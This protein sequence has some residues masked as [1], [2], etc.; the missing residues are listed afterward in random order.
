MKRRL[1]AL[2]GGV[3]LVLAVALPSSAGA[4]VNWLCDVPGEGTVVFVSA[5][6]A[7]RHGLVTAN[8]HAGQTF[9]RNFGKSFCVVKARLT[10][11]SRGTS[12]CAPMTALLALPRNARKRSYARLSQAR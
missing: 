4:N 10:P 8:A 5:A 9:N 3:G 7:A 12:T 6:D 2:I 1:K 11:R